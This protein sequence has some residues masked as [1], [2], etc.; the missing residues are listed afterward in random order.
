MHEVVVA[1]TNGAVVI[2][3]GVTGGAAG[4]M[5]D[6]PYTIFERPDNVLEQDWA[7]L[8]S[9]EAGAEEIAEALL[10]IYDVLIN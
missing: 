6:V 2:P 7:L 5:F 3:V 1:I 10:R 9:E 8:F 4:G